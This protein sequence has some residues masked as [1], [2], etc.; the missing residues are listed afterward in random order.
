LYLQ[1]TR[2]VAAKRDHAIAPGLQPT[3]FAMPMPLAPRPAEVAS[4][5]IAAVTLPDTRWDLC[6]IKAITLLPNVLLKHEAAARGA[7]EALLVRDGQ[8][9]EGTASNVFAV[10]D[11]ALLTPPLAPAMLPGVTRALVLELAA[12]NGIACREGPL[13]QA[14]LGDCSELWISS[15]TREVSPVTTLD[16]KPVG[17]GRPGPLWRRVDALYQAFKDALRRGA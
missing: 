15:S 17:D 12:A 3:V 6:H 11:G 13:P 8:V 4:H 9:L 7:A 16:G 14:R 2:G 1:V 5:G 10:L